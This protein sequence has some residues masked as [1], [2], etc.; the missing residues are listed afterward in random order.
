MPIFRQDNL[1]PDLLQF[2]N[3]NNN[4]RTDPTQLFGGNQGFGSNVPFNN[5][6]AAFGP[7]TSTSFGG[8]NSTSRRGGLSDIL[9]GFGNAFDSFAGTTRNPGVGRQLFGG[10]GALGNAAF[11]IAQFGQQKKQLKESKRQFN[12]NFEAQKTAF[13]GRIADQA[14]ARLSANPKNQTVEE[15][16]AER[17]I[18]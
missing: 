6:N 14:R 8:N 2:G 16:L 7:G 17:G 18:R 10:L 15:A 3:N 4:Q 12:Q 5:S 1:L 13:N 11:A 9:S